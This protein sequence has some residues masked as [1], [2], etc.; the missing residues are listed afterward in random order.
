[1]PLNL[2]KTMSDRVGSTLYVV[3]GS[4]ICHLVKK[5]KVSTIIFATPQAALTWCL[6]S[7]AVMIF[8][9]SVFDRQIQPK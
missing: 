5:K 7:K 6:E 3:E 2:N 9:P 4:P 8:T 1:M